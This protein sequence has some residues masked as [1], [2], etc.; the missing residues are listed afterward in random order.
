[1]VYHFL[2][3][4][5]ECGARVFGSP[6]DSLLCTEFMVSAGDLSSKIALGLS[7]DASELLL[8]GKVEDKRERNSPQSQFRLR[9]SEFKEW[10]NC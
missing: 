1:M 4:G 2:R 10:N 6:V 3:L 8:V 7:V 9:D 5:G